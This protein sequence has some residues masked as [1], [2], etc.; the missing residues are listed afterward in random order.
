M[1]GY[2]RPHADILTV[3]EYRIYQ[4]YY[5]GLCKAI[6]KKYGQVPRLALQYDVSAMALM[7][8]GISGSGHVPSG[9]CLLHP[10]KKRPV[11]AISPALEYAAAINVLLAYEK[12]KDDKNDGGGII[13]SAAM[14]GLHAAYKK[15]KKNLPEHAAKISEMLRE[16]AALEKAGCSSIEEYCEPFSRMMEYLFVNSPCVSGSDAKAWGYMAYWLGRWMTLADAYD[17]IAKD[18]GKR[19]NLIDK[20]C[21]QSRLGPDELK[22]AIEG[23][24]R[25]EMMYC[26][27]EAGKGLDLI[28]MKVNKSIAE[29]I[30]LDGCHRMTETVLKGRGKEDEGQQLS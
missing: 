29:N 15:A 25:F 6:G 10:T 1:F 16:T 4:G 3:R 28:N 21:N 5:C 27:A 7:L 24:V 12:L 23:T 18:Y 2:L 11:A 19:Y 13:P 26:L 20:A 8:D 9:R 17:D 22:K 14:A 30:V